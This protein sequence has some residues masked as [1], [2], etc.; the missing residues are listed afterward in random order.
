MLAEAGIE[1]MRLPPRSPNLTANAVRSV[2]TIKESCLD[3]LVL[4]GE[5]SL[6]KAVRE[7]MGHEHSQRNQQGFGNRLIAPEVCPLMSDGPHGLVGFYFLLTPWRDSKPLKQLAR[8]PPRTAVQFNP[9]LAH[10]RGS[11]VSSRAHIHVPGRWAK[12]LCIIIGSAPCRRSHAD[13]YRSIFWILRD[14]NRC[15]RF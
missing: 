2:R 13:L 4:F 12:M 6:R 9:F 15:P 10:R 1:S 14:V 8:Q 11:Q 5:A 3:H 7:F